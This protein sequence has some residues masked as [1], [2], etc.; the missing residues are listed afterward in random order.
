M[1]MKK[2]NRKYLSRI[3]S[4]VLVLALIV[5]VLSV[6]GVFAGLI[7][8]TSKGEIVLQPAKVTCTVGDDYA[9]TNTGDIP[10]VIRARIVANW[11]D[12]DGSVV[13]NAEDGVF[14]L[15]PSENWTH[16]N[17]TAVTAGE[18]YCNRII[19]PNG[20]TE[21]LLTVTVTKVPANAKRLEVKIL[22]EAL[23]AAGET[24]SGKTAAEDAWGVIP[25]FEGSG[26]SW[27]K[28]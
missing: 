25:A 15:A 13:A 17:G 3:L 14:Q 5:A 24:G 12:A 1:T 20:K 6:S 27:T 28:N 26:V 18:W 4:T 10:A 22:A 7:D 11:V 23:Q 2:Q 19:A 16:L 21:P 8:T 9:V